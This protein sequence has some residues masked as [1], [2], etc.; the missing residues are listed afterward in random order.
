MLSDE[1]FNIIVYIKEDSELLKR[2]DIAALIEN[3]SPCC[4]LQILDEVA[5]VE[6]VIYWLWT[7]LQGKY[8][9]AKAMD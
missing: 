2:N 6:T 9:K 5:N 4:P 3:I 1:D 7:M 8:G